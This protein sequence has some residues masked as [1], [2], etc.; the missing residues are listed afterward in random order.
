MV[1]IGGISL[2][3]FIAPSLHRQS[4]SPPAIGFA[5]FPNRIRL[6]STVALLDE[7]EKTG[8]RAAIVNRKVDGLVKSDCETDFDATLGNGHARNS[9]IASILIYFDISGVECC[10]SWSEFKLSR[11]TK[12][13][14]I[15]QKSWR[16]VHRWK[17][18]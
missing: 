2:P 12:C 1:A 9:G 13:L 3:R 8:S 17:F 6:R 10:S 11:L 5:R 16:V 7:V 15:R 18:Y 4:F 14:S